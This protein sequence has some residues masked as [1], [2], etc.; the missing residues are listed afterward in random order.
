[1]LGK[2]PIRFEDVQKNIDV[3]DRNYK[4]WVVCLRGGGYI[5][6]I[7]APYG[8]I[9]G[10]YKAKKKFKN[11]VDK[12]VNKSVGKKT[13]SAK[14]GTS[15]VTDMAHLYTK[16][17]TSKYIGINNTVDITGCSIAQHVKNGEKPFY[18]GKPMW[19]SEDCYQLKVKGSDE[20]WH[21]FGETAKAIEWH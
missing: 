6:T 11:D 9:I 15:Q 8:L 13:R 4:R 21:E 1:M 5:L 19:I 3:S 7:R 16:N 14:N 20:K 18:Q 2:R 10:V 17:G 12:S